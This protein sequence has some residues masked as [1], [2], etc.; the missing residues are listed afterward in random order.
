M[1]EAPVTGK[2]PVSFD[3]KALHRL[4]E[5]YRIAELSFF[6][7]V[8]RSDF[9][10]TRSDVDVLVEFL[11]DTPAKGYVW[12]DRLSLFT[13]EEALAEMLHCKVDLVDK[14]DLDPY[15]RDD[16]VNSRVIVYMYP[17]EPCLLRETGASYGSRPGDS[18]S[19]ADKAPDPGE[20]VKKPPGSAGTVTQKSKGVKKLDLYL[21]HMRDDCRYLLQTT[22]ELTYED[23][24]GNRDKQLVV[25][26]LLEEIGEN[27][28]RLDPV[29]RES[30]PE[31]G[32][33]DVIS[34]RNKMAHAYRHTMLY[35]MW[36]N[37]EKIPE[38]L[39]G[40]EAL[41]RETAV[42]EGKRD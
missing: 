15:I 8:T 31:I 29:F 28:N 34:F 24:A 30:H 13:M 23:F 17:S 12:F 1:A 25:G 19:T 33:K 9:D 22:A 36:R 5:I 6:G 3:E 2:F 4:C 7:S 18:R 42:P 41:I 11:P 40:I 26:K 21:F 14:E 20:T 35:S 32:W 27:A 39:A 37:K 10:H 38:L 16:V